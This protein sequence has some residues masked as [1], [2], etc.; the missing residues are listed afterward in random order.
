MDAT[1]DFHAIQTTSYIWKF[2]PSPS[3]HWRCLVTKIKNTE[4]LQQNICETF[5]C[6]LIFCLGSMAIK[7]K[8][9]KIYWMKNYLDQ[10]FH[11]YSICDYYVHCTLDSMSCQSPHSATHLK[12]TCIP[13]DIPHRLNDFV[14]SC[15]KSLSQHS[16]THS[17][18]RALIW[19]R[20]V[21]TAVYDIS[22]LATCSFQY[23]MLL[24]VKNFL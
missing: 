17:M 24:G 15:L 20:M 4:I 5:S 22:L 19:A 8:Q 23:F 7:I 1:C 16:P 21:P 3:I 14:M 2:L 9:N 11:I 6:R 10:I 12:I 18:H 13:M